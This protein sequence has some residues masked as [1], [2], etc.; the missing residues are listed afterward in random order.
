MDTQKEIYASNI[1]RRALLVGA[2]K[3]GALALL[4]SKSFYI[5][6][7]QSFK[8]SKL[9]DRN[10][11]E[12]KPLPAIRGEI[13][14]IYGIPLAL[15]RH[16]FK[17][18]MKKTDNLYLAQEIQLIKNILN[19]DKN[20]ENLFLNSNKINALPRLI[21]SDLS[22]KEISLIE[23]NETNLKNFFLEIENAR[24]YLYGETLGHILGYTGIT[25]QQD[26]KMSLNRSGISGL[27]LYY[28]TTLRGVPGYKEVERNAKGKKIKLLNQVNTIKG[29]DLKTNIDISLQAKV[30]ELL[31]ST[32]SAAIVVECNTGNIV[33]LVSKPNFDSNNLEN[34]N[35]EYWNNIN[36]NPEKPLLNKA[37]QGVYSPGSIFKIIT[38][39][40][41][42]EYGINPKQKFKCTGNNYLGKFNFRCAKKIGH[43]YLD[44]EEALQYSCNSYMYQVSKL[45]PQEKLIET[46]HA[47][48]IGELTNI[49]IPNEKKGLLPLKSWKIKKFG[50]RWSAGDS[51]NLSIGQGFI[52]TTP[53][54]LLMLISA[55]GNN[56][57]LFTPNIAN[58]A[59]NFREIPI[60]KESLKIIQSALYKAI[61][62]EGGTG[63]RSK[64]AHK[65]IQMSGKTGTVQVYKK[66]IKNENLSSSS[67]ETIKRNHSSFVGYMPSTNPQFAISIICEHMGDGASLAAPLAKQIF[68]YMIKQYSL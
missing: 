60:S 20:Q 25:N 12:I 46:A 40:A 61:N 52:L 53:I 15:N 67:T 29:Q 39:L 65:F 18:Y 14:D 23:E 45:I 59:L 13:Y 27:E 8:Y 66:T 47:L 56:G 28:E 24:K 58:R 54:Q 17:L 21:K 31:P 7:T 19:L 41:A 51:F 3:L 44:M 68:S 6:L 33:S 11:I 1:S 16:V 32:P 10:R 50:S 63:Y 4:A 22:W 30:S 34:F 64:L 43:G 26:T 62:N 49:D 38:T 55:I 48:G 5:Q 35:Y 36:I 57:K 9:S 42:L 37:I 2:C